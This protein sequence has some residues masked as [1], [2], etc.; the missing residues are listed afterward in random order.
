MRA[1]VYPYRKGSKSVKAL[2]RAIG[3]KSIKIEGS[4]FRP[5]PNKVVINWGSSSCPVGCINP[6]KAV[7]DA[8]NKLTAFNILKEAGVSIPLHTA[9]KQDAQAWV[10]E[11]KTVVVRH[12]LQGS[13]GDGIEILKGAALPVA[14]L[15]VQYIPKKEEYRV[16]V[17]N[18][19]VIDVQRKMRNRSV[20]DDAVNWQVRN[21]DNGFVFGREGVI[22]SDQA[23]RE[24][25]G[26]V[27]ALGLDFGA[28]DIIYN[29]HINKMY[30]LEVNTAPG[31]EGTTLETYTAGIQRNYL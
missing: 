14:P 15:Y 2:K 13:C 1:F 22:L 24:A 12:L 19:E 5:T 17:M 20:A 31:L 30:V 21:H 27:A 6:A 8:S 25:I 18:G 7:A 16:H 10:D 23:A 4:R 29:E 11:G 3:A 9:C 26:A 28:V